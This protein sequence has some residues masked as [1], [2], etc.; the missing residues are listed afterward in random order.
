M[1]ARLRSY[2]VG[3]IVTFMQDVDN[4]LYILIEL[5]GTLLSSKGLMNKSIVQLSKYIG[6]CFLSCVGG[7]FPC[8]D[9]GF[10]QSGH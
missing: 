5:I 2:F 10:L 9:C 1:V 3:K 4:T 8:L 6:R 7:K